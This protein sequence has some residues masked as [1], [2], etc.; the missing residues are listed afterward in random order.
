MNSDQNH[1][2]DIFSNIDSILALRPTPAALL[3][4][5]EGFLRN[6]DSEETLTKS[7]GIS[8][9]RLAYRHHQFRS[10][11]FK[12]LAL[13]D[14]PARTVRSV[15]VQL[16]GELKRLSRRHP[17]RPSATAVEAHLRAALAA[18]PGAGISE[19]QMWHVVNAY[20]LAARSNR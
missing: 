18:Y 1:T 15:A 5:K 6:L 10:E 4:L 19:T 3:W 9:L 13:M 12:A 17:G 20:R 16:A 2:T 14:D 8:G 7:L 11:V